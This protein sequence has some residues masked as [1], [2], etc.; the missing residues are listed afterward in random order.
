MRRAF[1]R[2]FFPFL[3]GV[4]RL[5]DPFWSR[6]TRRR[7]LGDTV[8]LVVVGRRTGQARRVMVGLLAVGDRRYV[9]HANARA[10]WLANLAAAG[11]G[12]LTVDGSSPILVRATRLAPGAE[13]DAVARAGGYQHPFPVDIAY[14]VAW[15][16]IRRDGVFFRIES[17]DGAPIALPARVRRI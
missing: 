10:A 15:A 14:R 5:T 8:E 17:L 16:S 11:E 3:Y 12:R 4:L 2:L 1:W 13:Q 6:L 7:G 9:G